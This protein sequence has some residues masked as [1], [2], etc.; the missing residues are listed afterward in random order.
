MWIA[1]G[2]AWATDQRWLMRASEIDTVLSHLASGRHGHTKALGLGQKMPFCKPRILVDLGPGKED[3][4][5]LWQRHRPG[6]VHATCW[7]GTVH[8]E[9]GR[10]GETRAN[11]VFQH[12]PAIEQGAGSRSGKGGR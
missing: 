10:I 9:H 5:P 4:P 3:E 11:E 6:G 1:L 12:Q 2:V 8:A 7:R